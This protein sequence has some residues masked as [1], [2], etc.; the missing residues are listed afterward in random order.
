MLF[1]GLGPFTW[2]WYLLSSCFNLPFF[3]SLIVYLYYLG[4]KESIIL[5]CSLSWRPL[6]E[7]ATP[8]T[9][10]HPVP[11]HSCRSWSPVWPADAYPRPATEPPWWGSSATSGKPSTPSLIS[12]PQRYG[13]LSVRRKSFHTW[14]KVGTGLDGSAISCG[15]TT[16]PCVLLV[17]FTLPGS[18]AFSIPPAGISAPSHERPQSLASTPC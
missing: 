5:H 8:V 15:H 14:S 3:F 17:S 10:R 18:T 6:E 2:E 11:W 12:Q 13:D 7:A 16:L 4:T 9:E 1:I